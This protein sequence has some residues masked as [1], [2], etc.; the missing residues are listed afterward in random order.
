[1]KQENLEGVFKRYPEKGSIEPPKGSIES[2]KR[3]YRSP[4]GSIEAQKVLSNPFRP[5][6]GFYRTLV[7]GTSE[8]QTGFYRTFRIEPSPFLGYPFKTLPKI[9]R[10]V[11]GSSCA[12]C[13]QRD[14]SI[15]R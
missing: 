3:F 5:Q 14:L 8:P 4:K 10:T 15:F 13:Y 6:K 2:L 1:M 11:L 12:P 9:R 7:R